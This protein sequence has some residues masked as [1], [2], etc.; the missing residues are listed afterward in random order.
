M[1]YFTLFYQFGKALCHFLYRSVWI[2][3]MLIEQIHIV[4]LK[5]SQRCFERT[6]Y[7]LRFAGQSRRSV[8]LIHIRIFQIVAEFCSYHDVIPIGFESFAHKFFVCSHSIYLR[9]IEKSDSEVNR[10]AYDIY[11]GRFIGIRRITLGKPHATESDCRYFKLV[12][13]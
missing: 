2:Y 6:A 7:Y 12:F 10:F 1:Q 11:T 3:A 9:G 5:A 4:C 13:S 8:I